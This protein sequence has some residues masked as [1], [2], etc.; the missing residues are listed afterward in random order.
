MGLGFVVL[1]CNVGLSFVVRG[2]RGGRNI[3]MSLHSALRTKYIPLIPIP[4]PNIQCDT[5]SS[6]QMGLRSS[7]CSSVQR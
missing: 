2:G 6:L 3:C 5:Q 4:V 1:E 7:I